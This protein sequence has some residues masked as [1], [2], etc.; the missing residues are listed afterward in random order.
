MSG[1]PPGHTDEETE[2]KEGPPEDVIPPMELQALRSDASLLASRGF[3]RHEGDATITPIRGMPAIVLANEVPGQ[4]DFGAVEILD[5]GP[6]EAE[7]VEQLEAALPVQ[8]E[9]TGAF[10]DLY[11]SQHDRLVRLAYVLTGSREVAEDVVQDS[12]VRLYRHWLAAEKPEQYVRQIVVN[13]CRSHHR[14]TGRQ[15]D[16]MAKLHVVDSTIDRHGVELSDVLLELPYRQRAAI[17]LRF[18]SDLSEAEIAEVLGCRP[19]TVGSL[20][21]RGLARLRMVIEQ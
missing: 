9:D 10:A 6:D 13:G 17:V 19:G 5:G 4:A 18:Y 11:V 21:H 15:R 8:L 12:F 1:E 2:C 14:R 20:I 7:V 16:K 3:V